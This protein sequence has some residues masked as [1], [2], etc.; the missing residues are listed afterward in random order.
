MI[1]R[2]TP[3]SPTLN[4]TTH[5]AGQVAVGLLL[6]WLSVRAIESYNR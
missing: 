1:A 2:M 3:T 6:T 5:A 4:S